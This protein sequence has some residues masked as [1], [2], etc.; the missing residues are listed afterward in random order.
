MVK[1]LYLMRHGQTRFNQLKRIQGVCDSPLT[2]FGIEQA[3]KARDYFQEL[4]LDFAVVYSSTQERAV[5]TAEIA[6]GRKDIRRL[7][8]LKEMDFGTFEGQSETLNPPL[9][10]GIGYGDY[11]VQHGGEDSMAVRERMVTTITEI[12]K[13]HQDGEKIL[14]IS[15]GA[16][17][18]QFYRGVMDNPPQVRMSNCAILKFNVNVDRFCLQ[19]IFNPINQE[20]LYK[21]EKP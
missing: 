9:T 6:S 17:I 7:K 1:T 20:Y 3:T 19:F 12:L 4:G 14:V 16:S 21:T 13:Q 10:Q 11:F 8:G 15:H 18:A 5:D 2:D